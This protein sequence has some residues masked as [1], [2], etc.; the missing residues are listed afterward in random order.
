MSRLVDSTL[1]DRSVGL[2]IVAAT[3]NVILL[4]VARLTGSTAPGLE[5]G[6]GVIE[7]FGIVNICVQVAIATVD[8]VLQAIVRWRRMWRR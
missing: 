3:C 4:V 1:L 7:A 6:L 8:D 2:V 5:T